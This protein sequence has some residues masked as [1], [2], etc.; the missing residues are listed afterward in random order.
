MSREW[1]TSEKVII[2]S[3]LFGTS[4]FLLG[5][6]LVVSHSD[7]FAVLLLGPP[8]FL[9]LFVFLKCLLFTI[10]YYENFSYAYQYH[11]GIIIAHGKPNNLPFYKYPCEIAKDLLTYFAGIELIIQ[12]FTKNSQKPH[13]NNYRRTRYRIYHCRKAQNF[14]DIVKNQSVRNLWIF[15]AW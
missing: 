2:G 14:I 1:T 8:I 13:D 9:L 7:L 12:N 10:F 5:H 15:W 6:A 11:H 4:F 3:L